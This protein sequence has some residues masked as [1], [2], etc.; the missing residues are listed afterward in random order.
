M[1]QYALKD[2]DGNEL[3]LA[4][5]A[6]FDAIAQNS[7][8]STSDDFSWENRIVE[9]SYL[10]GSIKL[11]VSRLATRDLTFEYS[12]AVGE[13][14]DA[15]RNDENT[16]MLWLNKVVYLVDKSNSLQVRVAVSS[17][18]PSYES[19]AHKISGDGEFTFILLDPFWENVTADTHAESL[20]SGTTNIAL[21]ND[22]FLQVPAI[23]EMIATV[24]VTSIQLYVVETNEGIEILDD[25]FG[26]SGFTQMVL[27]CK[28][29]TLTIE[30]LDRRN[31]ITVGTGFFDFPVGSFTLRCVL[32]AAL[33]I[34]I[35]WNERTF[36]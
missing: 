36:I 30:D 25:V 17:H 19:G 5:D 15:Y 23:F 14:E 35:D 33:D 10:S 4:T 7:L 27:D 31:K 11:G 13:D 24:A 3:N 2:A 34:S 8:T 20:S 6:E 12:R 1:I 21:S 28:E 26:N 18:T 16:L 22:G 29:G 9:K 32:S